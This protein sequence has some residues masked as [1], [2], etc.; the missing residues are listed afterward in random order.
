VPH[1]HIHLAPINDMADAN[2]TNAKRADNDALA[3]A[4]VKIR[5]ALA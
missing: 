3:A 4:A 5:A 1:T 2:I